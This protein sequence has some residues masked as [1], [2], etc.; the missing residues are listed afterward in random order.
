MVVSLRLQLFRSIYSEFFRKTQEGKEMFSSFVAHE[1]YKLV[2]FYG[3]MVNENEKIVVWSMR[4]KW[5]VENPLK[6]K[7]YIYFQAMDM[8]V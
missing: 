5:V 2:L 3:Y 8:C 1:S 7:N 6:I 4:T